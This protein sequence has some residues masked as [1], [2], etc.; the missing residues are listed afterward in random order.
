MRDPASGRIPQGRALAPMALL[1]L[2]FL[3]SFAPA[4]R[5]DD[6]PQR[7]TPERRQELQRQAVELSRVGDQA[8][9]R[10][11]LTTAVEK[12]RRLLQIRERL[13]PKE[14]YPQGHHDLALSLNNLGFLLWSQGDYGGARGYLSG[15]WRCGRRSIPRIATP[16]ATPT[17][18]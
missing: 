16:T 1:M 7:L 2:L 14:S 13:Y 3:G 10:G 4:G 12:N 9:Q 6:P 15:R 18:P 5:A 17:W 8:Y 11:D